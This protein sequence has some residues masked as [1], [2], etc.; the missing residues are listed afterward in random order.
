MFYNGFLKVAYE[1]LENVFLQTFSGN[2]FQN[3]FGQTFPKR[4]LANVFKTFSCKRFLANVSQMFSG[5]HMYGH[6]VTFKTIRK[7]WKQTYLK[8]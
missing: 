7:R 6:W 1:S 2:Y 4:F 5:K 3:I 8:R